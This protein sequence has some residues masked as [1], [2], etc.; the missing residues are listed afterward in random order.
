[1]VINILYQALKTKWAWMAVAI[2]IPSLGQVYKYLGIPGF[3]AFAS[4]TGACMFLIDKKWVKVNILLSKK[5]ASLILTAIIVAFLLVIFTMIYPDANAGM[6]R[7]GS[8]DGDALKIGAKAVL[9]LDLSLI[10]I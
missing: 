6:Y 4:I 10:H 8:D 3:I 7:G 5:N 2:A 1:M 9:T